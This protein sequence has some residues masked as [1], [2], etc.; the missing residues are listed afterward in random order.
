MLATAAMVVGCSAAARTAA[1]ARVPVAGKGAG[2]K[3]VVLCISGNRWEGWNRADNSRHRGKFLPNPPRGFAV[4]RKIVIVKTVND[5]GF[6]TGRYVLPLSTPEMVL[7][8]LKRQVS[9]AGCAP[10]AV[11]SL[12]TNSPSGFDVSSV[13]ADVRQ[14]SGLLADR[15]TCDLRIRLDRWRNGLKVESTYYAS[16][17]S[18]SSIL[19]RDH[20][21]AATIAKAVNEVTAKAAADIVRA[22]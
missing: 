4:P 2:G 3:A 19:G 8:D 6:T 7:D 11:R 9:A 22:L 20:V 5:S 16:T 12:P 13:Q 1:P 18:G 17:V 15:A 21:T 10:V 14:R